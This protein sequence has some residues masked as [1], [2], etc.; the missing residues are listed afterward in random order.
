MAGFLMNRQRS[1]ASAVPRTILALALAIAIVIAAV[2]GAIYFITVKTT[3][4]VLHNAKEESFDTANRM[5]TSFK[6][7]FN[8]TPRVTVGGVTVIEQ[9]SSVVELATVQQDIV[10][11]YQW[12]K[13][14][15]GSS[16]WR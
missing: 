15:L 13:T 11:H 7:A 12:S 14:W 2:T 3:S 10:E 6:S 4:T 5:V 9:A 16:R 1:H 8:F